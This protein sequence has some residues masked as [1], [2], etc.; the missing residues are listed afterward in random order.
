MTAH[1]MLQGFIMRLRI[2]IDSDYPTWNAMAGFMLGIKV[3][4]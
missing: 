3:K 2:W 4:G 1:K